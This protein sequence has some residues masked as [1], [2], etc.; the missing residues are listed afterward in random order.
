MH[1][2]NFSLH[3]C[4]ALYNAIFGCHCSC[5]LGI[6]NRPQLMFNLTR[7]LSDGNISLKK[8]REKNP[9][10]LLV[11][12][13]MFSLLFSPIVLFIRLYFT[14]INHIIRK[15]KTGWTTN[16]IQCN[17][18]TAYVQT[19]VDTTPLVDCWGE[20]YVSTATSHCSYIKWTV[21]LIGLF[22]AI[23]FKI[24]K[25]DIFCTIQHY[26]R[27][28]LFSQEVLQMPFASLQKWYI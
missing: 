13:T 11:E 19:P 20:L 16:Y 14:I 28:Q 21:F 25:Q 18:K 24:W 7:H 15:N 10:P 26:I 6:S 5:W 27:F 4:H 3:S 22:T 2:K 12:M 8:V 23:L 9:N 1:N 17:K